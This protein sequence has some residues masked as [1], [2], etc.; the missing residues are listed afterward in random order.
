[1]T[2][3]TPHNNGPFKALYLPPQAPSKALPSRPP[4]PLTPSQALVKVHYSAVNPGD[5]RHFHMGMSGFVMGYDHVGTV[6]TA[7]S[8]SALSAKFPA[9]TPV[10]GMGVPFHQRPIHLG[11][12]QAY[13][14]ADLELAPHLTWKR[15]E[16]LNP[17]DAVGMP[18]ALLTAADGLVGWAA[19]QLARAA[20]FEEI[21]VTAR[22]RNHGLLKEAGATR[23]FDYSKG[24]EAVV[25][26][27]R[28]VVREL[29]GKGM[30][31]DAVFD[32]VGAGLGIWAGLDEETEKKV[33]GEF[34]KS[35]PAL[36][37]R[38]LSDGVVEAGEAK[39][40]CVLPVGKDQDYVFAIF[41]RRGEYA[42]GHPEWSERQEKVVAWMIQ[43]H[44][45]AWRPWPKTRVVKDAD[46][47]IEAVK[48]VYSGRVSQERVVIEH[49][50][51]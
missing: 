23:C 42:F 39:L 27:I 19:V 51:L 45:T 28:A 46:A 43:N 7:P 21:L 18:N 49:P 24:A 37:K 34:D 8:S 4:H 12:H 2:S 5:L 35:T 33:E 22:E 40:C 3:T 17:L 31:L 48:D 47:A 36:A 10:F 25:A 38:C 20:G 41:T 1:M 16:T 29:E 44:K 6:I 32:A 50:M 26:E 14:L 9:G 11:A 13:L 30:R 15:P